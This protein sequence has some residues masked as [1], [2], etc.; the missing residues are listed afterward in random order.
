MPPLEPITT[1]PAPSAA[2]NH[3]NTF[4]RIDDQSRPCLSSASPANHPTAHSVPD[5]TYAAVA[6]PA[7]FHLAGPELQHV[8]GS[9]DSAMGN[10]DPFWSLPTSWQWTHEDLYLQSG[11]FGPFPADLGGAFPAACSQPDISMSAERSEAP[12]APAHGGQSDDGQLM[13]DYTRSVGM[14]GVHSDRVITSNPD[15]NDV[16]ARMAMLAAVRDEDIDWS[17][18]SSRLTGFIEL[19]VSEGPSDDAKDLLRRLVDRYYTHF[20]PLWPLVPSKHS[21]SADLHPLLYLTM[22]SIG[23]L[24]SGAA[25]AAKY[26]A[27]MHHRLRN[28]LL[29]CKTRSDQTQNEALDFGRAMLLTQVAALYFEQNGAFSAA[30]QL[31]ARLYAYAHRMRLFI[32]QHPSTQSRFRQ[33]LEEDAALAEG[34]RMLAFGILR[35]ET[36]M[37][38]LF[39]R[40]PILSYEEINLPLPVARV[41]TPGVVQGERSLPSSALLF[42]DLVRLVLDGEEALPPLRPV[43]LELLMFGLQGEVWRFSHDLDIFPRLMRQ[44]RPQLVDGLSLNNFDLSDPPTADFLDRTRRTMTKLVGEYQSM[45]KA[46]QK[47]QRATSQAQLLYSVE[48]HRSEYLSGFILLEVGLLRLCAP[49]DAMLQVAYHA[50]DPGNIEQKAHE[51][52][53]NWIATPEVNNAISHARNIW[54]MLDAETSRD[55]TS[56]AKYNILALIALHIAAVVIW[57]IAGS[58]KQ[59]EEC[60][61][62]NRNAPELILRRN[63][64]RTLML[65]FDALSRKVSISWGMQ[66]SFSRIVEQLAERPFLL[67]D[68]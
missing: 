54:H 6:P 12:L 32:C 27:L 52:V 15:L 59:P 19:P 17:Q 22:S 11:A 39:N 68:T 62:G 67:P 53:A 60:F 35:A 4:Y 66:S 33:E 34:R 16:V 46:L 31:G 25:A 37:S 21:A 24:Y 63:N 1:A 43:D 8:D 48:D 49:T 23:A 61:L 13:S 51:D 40:K 29:D 41:F 38:V 58:N 47:W 7:P 30:E 5:H 57:T 18:W 20:H 64:T 56:Q 50:R 10:L 26:G 65:S 2:N 3:E 36:Y 9:A 55:G 45:L 28:T 44:S 14:D 42:S